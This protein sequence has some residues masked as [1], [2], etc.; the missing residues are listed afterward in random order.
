MTTST[1]SL[2]I[3]VAAAVEARREARRE[4]AARLAHLVDWDRMATALA[5][6]RLLPPLGPRLI[7]LGDGATGPRFE[8]AVE[9]AIEAARRQALLLSSTAGLVEAALAAAEVRSAPL[10]GPQLA[11][12]IYG[13]PGR[14]LAGDVDVLVDRADLVTAVRVVEGLGY[15]APQDPRGADGLPE[16]HF[17]LAHREGRLPPVELHWRIH[18]YERRFAAERLLPP[19]DAPPGWRPDAAAELAS[20]LLY[21]ARD[22]FV[23]LRLAADLGAWWDRRGAELEPLALERIVAAH[24]G[25]DRAVR[26]AARVASRTIGMPSAGQLTPRAP[27]LRDRLAVE[28]A[29]PHPSRGEVQTYAEIG[30]IDG[31]LTPRGGGGALVRRQILIPDEVLRRRDELTGNS[32]RRGPFRA[33]TRRG[34]AF[35]LLPRVG[36]LVFYLLAL[37]RAVHSARARKSRRRS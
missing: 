11:E 36:V 28:L 22:G 32:G 3:E 12:A 31:L 9:V 37:G 27:A 26:V 20:L 8:A 33:G 16:L 10:K 34:H 35:R 29:N 19:P 13:D 24:P 15:A 18:W 25:L 1:A 7:A 17:S 23:D 6:R 14:R 21:Y 30:L 4:E 5:W 2:L